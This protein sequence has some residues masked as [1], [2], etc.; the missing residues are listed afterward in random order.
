VSSWRR[1]LTLGQSRIPEILPHLGPICQTELGHKLLRS[2]E[3]VTVV[4]VGYG[5]SDSKTIGGGSDSPGCSRSAAYRLGF[6]A[7]QAK[8]IVDKMSRLEPSEQEELRCLSRKLGRSEGN[9][10]SKKDE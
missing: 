1:R 8:A 2:G 6:P 5:A 4:I 10:D 3:N 7:R 9:T